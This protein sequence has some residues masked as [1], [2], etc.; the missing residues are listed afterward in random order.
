MPHDN[1][2]GREDYACN[3]ELLLQA[4]RKMIE[5]TQDSIDQS[6]RLLSGYDRPPGAIPDH[7]HRARMFGPVRGGIVVAPLPG[8]LDDCIAGRHPPASAPTT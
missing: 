6:R 7:E 4:I 1:P 5:Q 3:A 2:D 8:R